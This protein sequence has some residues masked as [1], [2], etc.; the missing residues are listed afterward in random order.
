MKPEQI[1]IV[2]DEKMIVENISLC[3]QKEGYRAVGAYNGDEA[4]RFFEQHRFDLVLLDISMPGMNGYEVM[5]RIYGL[6]GE[7]LVIIITGY[8]SIESAVRA[9]KI[10]AWDYFKKPF[11]YADLIKTVKMP[12]P[13]KN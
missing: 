10:G 9:L 12:F 6:D 8:A 13:R 3:L 7:V 4:I 1:L 2:D 5:E 11:E